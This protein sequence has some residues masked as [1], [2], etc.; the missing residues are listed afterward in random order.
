MSPLLLL[1]NTL[2]LDVQPMK[3][4]RCSSSLCHAWTPATVTVTATPASCNAAWY[5]IDTGV[6]VANRVSFE[7]HA[8][9]MSSY[10]AGRCG[11]T[12]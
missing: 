2:E 5:D 11:N 9:V 4:A 10:G 12:N 1:V 7:A 3:N 6:T 8:I